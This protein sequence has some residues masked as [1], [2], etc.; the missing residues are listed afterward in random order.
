MDREL[1]VSS[2]EEGD[3]LPSLKTPESPSG[4]PPG[5]G[6]LAEIMEMA[7]NVSN[8]SIAHEIVINHNFHF[9][10]RK[11]PTDS[12]EERVMEI[13][14]RAFWDS[15]EAQLACNPPD[16]T[17]AIRLL[18]EVKETLLSL[19]LPAHT[20]LRCQINEVLDM[21][22]IKQQAKHGALD[23]K[24]LSSYITATMASLCAPVRDEEIKRLKELTD[25]VSLLRETLRVLNLMKMDMVNF[26]I[27]A[28]RPTL[29]QNAVQYERAKFQEIID[30]QPG[31][32]EHTT[33]W[34]K[35][36]LE[37]IRS[38]SNNGESLPKTISPMAVL[39]R[40]YLSLLK[41]NSKS[42]VY[43]ETVRMDQS[44]MEEI[45]WRIEQA[46]L[47]ASVL[48]VTSN[49]CWGGIF[50]LPEFVSK[51]KQVIVALLQG[52]HLRSFDLQAALSAIG[53][54]VVLQVNQTL[55][56][57][58]KEAMNTQ[59]ASLLCGQISDIAKENN[60]V[61][62]LIGSRIQSV[63][64]TF[65]GSAAYKDGVPL[66]GGLSPVST[67]LAEIGRSLGQLVQYNR[68][69][70]GP[71]YSAILREILIPQSEVDSAEGSR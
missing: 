32:L 14:H 11:P 7:R 15:L 39:N 43:P 2:E 55:C 5:P 64:H 65:L 38:Q 54:Q 24:R 31:A 66:P 35:E 30:K 25:I 71:Y 23:L 56:D 22:L 13:M 8:L 27:Q 52:S 36:A 1:P 41:H 53:E 29:L 58:G 63:L 10:Q 68:L 45:K 17:N 44:R 46:I 57:Q 50:L 47:M 26:T 19:L 48:L 59:Q 42:Q 9:K 4:S 34:L 49:N 70:F 60:P 61:R 16:Y 51:L 3:D 37:D 40:A 6:N 21:D 62:T 67:E 12:F 18:Q 20:Q 33:V 69:V 28:F